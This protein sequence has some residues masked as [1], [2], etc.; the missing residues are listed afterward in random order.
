[1][2]QLDAFQQPYA[3]IIKSHD[4]LV[5][6][7]RG[8]AA[9]IDKS[10]ASMFGRAGTKSTHP[11]VKMVEGVVTRMEKARRRL[12]DVAGPRLQQLQEC[13]QLHALKQKLI[14]VVGA[15]LKWV[16]GGGGGGGGSERGG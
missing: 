7:G 12:E 3:R 13:H 10:D 16:E 1:M 4:D 11:A 15:T 5:T 8:I 2:L 14:K 6:M 9:E